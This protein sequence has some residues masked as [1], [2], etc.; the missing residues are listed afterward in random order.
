MIAKY[1]NIFREGS[2]RYSLTSSGG[3]AEKIAANSNVIYFSIV[4]FIYNLTVE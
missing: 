4:E 3:K 2:L 1:M